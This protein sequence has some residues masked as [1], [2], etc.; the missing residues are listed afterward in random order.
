MVEHIV[1]GGARIT[2]H[3]L[4]AGGK[5]TSWPDIQ[6]TEVGGVAIRWQ[7]ATATGPCAR[8]VADRVL[9]PFAHGRIPKGTELAL[10][11][12]VRRAS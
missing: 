9:I 5:P 4:V 11:N 7:F 10:R 6:S 8:P 1:I 3:E 2:A 12:E